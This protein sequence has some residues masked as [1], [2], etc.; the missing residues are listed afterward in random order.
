MREFYFSNTTNFGDAMNAWIWQRVFPATMMRADDD[1][2][3]IGIGSLIKKELEYVKGLKVVFGTGSGYGNFPTAQEIEKWHVYFVRGP[4]TARFLG[5]D[6]SKA[7]IDA[8]WLISQLEEFKL[9]PDK[10]GTVF[11]PH[12]TTGIN[13]SWENVCQRADVSFI[14]PL[15]DTF[16]VIRRIASA[17]L[18]IVESLH[19]AIIADYF[20]TPWIPLILSESTLPFKWV[21]WCASINVE[22]SPYKLPLSDI[23]H[24]LSHGKWPHFA[25]NYKQLSYSDESI[26]QA[27]NA[28]LVPKQNSLPRGVYVAR[29]KLRTTLKNSA[30]KCRQGV[31]PLKNAWPLSIW[32]DVQ[33]DKLAKMLIEIKSAKATLSL[34]TVRESKIAQLSELKEQLVTEYPMLAAKAATN[35]DI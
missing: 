17:E 6:K 4:L 25:G 30:L 7:V 22:Y 33:N 9:I 29:N 31:L 26:I 21:D 10:K 2:R 28:S 32:N 18:A 19:G 24:H 34:D 15:D 13:S 23:Y 5:L 1:I 27:V 3:L 14:N 8:A 16:D 20:R 35:R 12:F 11:V